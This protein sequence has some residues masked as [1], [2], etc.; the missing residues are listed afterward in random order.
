MKKKI[1]NVKNR[2]ARIYFSK[3]ECEVNQIKDKQIVEVKI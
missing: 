3:E 1:Q 2:G